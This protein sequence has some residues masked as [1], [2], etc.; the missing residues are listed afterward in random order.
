MRVGS[1]PERRR[2]NAGWGPGDRSAGVAEAV[3]RR[4]P[5]DCEPSPNAVVACQPSARA[6]ATASPS[7]AGHASRT[8]PGQGHALA[9]APLRSAALTG[10]G[11]LSM[12]AQEAAS[13]VVS[14][15]NVHRSR[16]E[17]G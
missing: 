2:A 14:G 13:Y 3:P 12:P 11:T 5:A 16:V 17:A 9:G 15:S 1:Q 7:G 10:G 8:T 6:A 4:P